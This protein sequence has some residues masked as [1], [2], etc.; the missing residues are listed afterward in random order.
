MS[1]L[2]ALARDQDCT[3]RLPGCDGGG[4][5]TVS[6]HYR[7]ATGGGMKPDD[8]QAADA[9]HSCHDIVDGRKKL[10][11]WTRDAIRLAHAEGVFRTQEAR[12]KLA[13]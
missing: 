11:G 13:A 10:E 4:A 2:R 12:R 8:Q 3:I 7:L 9:C 6:A 5:T 1:R